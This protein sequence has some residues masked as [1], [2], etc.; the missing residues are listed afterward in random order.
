MLVEHLP[1]EG[2]KLLRSPGDRD[3]A[4]SIVAGAAH[5]SV[6][7]L[8]DEPALP[9]GLAKALIRRADVVVSTDSGPRHFAQAFDVP[10]VTLFGPTHIGWTETWHPR[11]IHL[12]KQV[13][14]GPCQQR[15]CPQGHHRCMNELTV[16]EVQRACQ[17]ILGIH[18][19][20]AL[21]MARSAG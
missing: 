8:A 10:V 3:E 13:D 4:R 16:E 14:C 12:Q 2:R 6:A 11:A 5:P 15:V 17:T 9:F 18:G 1:G 20:H 19:G 7:S 21:P